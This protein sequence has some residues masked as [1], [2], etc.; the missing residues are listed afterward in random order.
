MEITKS[1][2]ITRLANLDYACTEALN[3]LCTNLSFA[4]NAVKKIMLT[5]CQ[6]MEGK[7]F[8]SINLLRALA[9]LGK[10]VV[11]VDADLR[12]SVAESRYGI[13]IKD[14]KKGLSH[15]LA[16]MC[17]MED[18]IYQTNID[19]AY[20]VIEGRGVSNSLPLLSTPMLSH[21]LDTLAQSFDIV[22]VDVPPVGIIIDAAM[23]ARSCDGALFIVS[24]S[25]IS[26]RELRE[27]K[28]Q[29][30]KAGCMILGAVLNK[31][32]FS[33]HGS[34][35]YYY[36]TYYTHYT[37]SDYDTKSSKRKARTQSSGN[38]RSAGDDD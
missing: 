14:D 35:K 10:K 31:V 32:S 27:A 6:P 33:T 15:Y 19:G 12:R 38:R 3:T 37:N 8:I 18:V 17:D 21:L 24:D 34:K 29:I 36:K 11:L 7:S 23:V 28:Q 4:G 13:V 20:M 26:R 25:I 5:S 9:A 16:G 30:E 2:S 1:L 22:L